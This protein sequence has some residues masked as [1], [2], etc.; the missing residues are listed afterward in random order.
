MLHW[1]WVKGFTSAQYNWLR[2]AVKE[3]E[4][5][6]LQ[7]ELLT[8]NGILLFVLFGNRE[9]ILLDLITHSNYAN[10]FRRIN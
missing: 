2:E 6:W 10:Q 4:S 3:R 8:S 1:C 5:S 7:L 9:N